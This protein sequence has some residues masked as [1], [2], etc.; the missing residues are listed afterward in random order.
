MQLGK[1]E[2]E[3]QSLNGIYNDKVVVGIGLKLNIQ[4]MKIMVS[5]LYGK[6][7]G[8]WQKQW[9]TLFWG[10]RKSLQVMTDEMTLTP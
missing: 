6:Q 3:R 8:K 10:A 2:N 1:E 9:L 7:M 4:K 5:S